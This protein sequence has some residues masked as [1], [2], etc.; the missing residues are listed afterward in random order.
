MIISPANYRQRKKKMFRLEIK[1]P[2][3]LTFAQ[4]W[5]SIEA[6][7]LGTMSSVHYDDCRKIAVIVPMTEWR[8]AKQRIALVLN[9]AAEVL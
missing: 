4:A 6:L 8:A 5:S 1:V 3:Q 7:R 2:V 9:T